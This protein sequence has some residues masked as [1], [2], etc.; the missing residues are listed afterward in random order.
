MHPK[1]PDKAAGMKR[2]APEADQQAGPSKRA[3]LEI[4]KPNLATLPLEVRDQIVRNI[5]RPGNFTGA[6]GT[7][8][9]MRLTSRSLKEAVDHEVDRN[10]ISSLVQEVRRSRDELD[11]TP[12]KSQGLNRKSAKLRY[13]ATEADFLSLESPD[14]RS[15]LVKD[16]LNYEHSVFPEDAVRNLVSNLE[17]L[18]PE[19]R[20]RV[21]NYVLD[22]HQM[23]LGG[24]HDLVRQ[25]IEK[26][27]YLPAAQRSSLVKVSYNSAGAERQRD[28]PLWADKTHLLDDG[29]EA[30]I[31][32]AV[33]ESEEGKGHL[34][35][36][37]AKN[38]KGV[39]PAHR[40]DLADEILK[41]PADQEGKWYA[42][43]Y[44]AKNLPDLA[45]H[46]QRSVVS[47]ISERLSEAVEEA[48]NE[49]AVWHTDAE[50]CKV[51]AAHHLSTH[52]QL[53]REP[54]RRQVSAFIDEIVYE[55]AAPDYARQAQLITH[56][57]DERRL[58]VLEHGLDDDGDDKSRV[59][60]GLTAR[61]ENLNASEKAGYIS[62][63]SEGN[64]MENDAAIAAIDHNIRNNLSHFSEDQRTTLVERH[65]HVVEHGDPSYAG[66]AIGGIAQGS[67]FLRLEDIQTTIETA[68]R[69]VEGNINDTALGNEAIASI[70][71][72]TGHAARSLAGWASDVLSNVKQNYRENRVSRQGRPQL[73]QRNRSAS[74][75]R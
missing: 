61:V 8:E 71:S 58:D 49:E 13:L 30:K 39:S 46:S 69:V 65:L 52:P 41:L 44:L 63:L 75:E 57:P 48:V 53:L 68:R 62:A 67:K 17:Y 66:P 54:A 4:A 35:A 64:V 28:L 3:R 29:D 25:L 20:S 50:F 74:R 5:I 36:G 10:A 18:K 42:L 14:A 7:L 40:A 24:A 31:L 43:N 56:L 38:L 22:E 55:S 9:N 23:E 51:E 70:Q 26:S 15:A 12:L 47:Q 33:R 27:E 6:L 11:E 59:I 73:D 60:C 45:E 16:T 19:E 37:F 72:C 34:L 2:S 32:V 21:A 1:D